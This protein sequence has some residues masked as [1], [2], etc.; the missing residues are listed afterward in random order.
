MDAGRFR[1]LAARMDAN[2]VGRLG[3]RA[4]LA[5]GVVIGGAFAS[6]FI[7]AAVGGASRTAKLGKVINAEKV[8]EPTF[9][10][11]AVD[12]VELVKG[13]VLTIDLP[14]SDGGGRLRVVRLEPDGSGMVDVIL[15][16]EIER[17]DDIT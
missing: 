2:L 14:P 6:P 1:G 8:M 15:G 4:T 5:S 13:S 17:T 3:D 12:V 11:R 16:A 10:A 7:G 9:T